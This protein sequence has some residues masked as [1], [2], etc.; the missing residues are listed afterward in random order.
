MRNLFLAVLV[1]LVAGMAGSKYFSTIQFYSSHPT[2][3]ALL[4]EVLKI[5]DQGKDHELPSHQLVNFVLQIIA[6]KNNL[7]DKSLLG[8]S[9]SEAFSTKNKKLM[10]DFD[11]EILEARKM[12]FA[13][14]SDFQL[15]QYLNFMKSESHAK[16]SQATLA[17]QDEYIKKYR[18]TRNQF[19]ELL[20]LQVAPLL[21]KG[22]PSDSVKAKPQR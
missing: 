3:Q 1:G 17:Y 13:G 15:Y 7:T 5:E 14:L 21:K 12:K 9:V 11:K 20:E 22:Q 2:R 16:V 10:D 4:E 8:P 18:K 6:E 19:T